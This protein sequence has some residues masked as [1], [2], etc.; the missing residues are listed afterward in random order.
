[1]AKYKSGLHKKISAIFGNV[2]ISK[3]DNAEQLPAT[4]EGGS[5]DS[6][7]PKPSV[8]EQ[9]LSSSLP[10]RQTAQ[11]S[12]ATISSKKSV[13]AGTVAKTSVQ[14]FLGQ[15]WKQI[16]SKVFVP[17]AGVD[18]GRHK[19]MVILMPVLLVVFIFIIIRVL[20]QP[21]PKA[22]RAQNPGKANVDSS[23]AISEKKINWQI[24][25]PYPAS[26]RDP[27]QA[28]LSAGGLGENGSLVVKGIVYSDDKP[29]A[30]VDNQIVHQGDKISGATIVRINKNDIE[31]EMD[32]KKWTQGV[33]R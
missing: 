19:T 6:A 10:P 33:Q 13:A 22:A 16:K 12:P 23:V 9:L 4:S 14:S 3:N 29:S 32:G 28:G 1:M 17:K 18:A 26:L 30:V 2:P 24:P 31:F 25:D 7:S 21:S 8:T 27:M 15:H 5:P 11:P 20:N